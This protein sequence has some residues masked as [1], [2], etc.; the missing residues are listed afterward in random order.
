MVFAIIGRDFS[1]ADICIY[2][3]SGSSLH[4][5][6]FHL[7]EKTATAFNFIQSLDHRCHI[8]DESAMVF[9]GVAIVFI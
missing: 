8:D 9:C 4:K 3:V 1:A 7:P 6:K 5:C 2:P